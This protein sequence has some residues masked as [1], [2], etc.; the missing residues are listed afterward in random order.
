M[1]AVFN[2]FGCVFHV[3]RAKKGIL[4]KGCN[5]LWLVVLKVE[6]PSSAASKASLVHRGYNLAK[7]LQILHVTMCNFPNENTSGC[8]ITALSP[9]TLI[10]SLC[11]TTI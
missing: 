4:S 11:K 7:Y 9:S 10:E 8:L 5:N 1:S 3:E 2:F 6:A